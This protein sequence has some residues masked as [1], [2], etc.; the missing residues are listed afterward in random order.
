MN[1]IPAIL[2]AGLALPLAGCG[3][4]PD[5]AANLPA[6]GR[7]PAVATVLRIPREGGAARLYRVPSLE[8]SAWKL[9]DK[10]PPLQRTLG[11]DAEQGFVF[12]L[13]KKRNVVAL[14]LETRR[15]R[16]SLEQVRHATVGPDGALY[17]VDTGSAVTQMMRRTPVRFRSKFQGS[18][19]ELHGTMGGMLVARLAGDQPRVEVLGS[20][21]PP[22]TFAVPTGPQSLTFWGD[23]VAVAAD[24]AVVIYETE[25]DSEGERDRVSIPVSGGAKAVMFSPS[26]HRIYVARASE[27]L[28]ILDRVSGAELQEI[29]LPGP[30][31][32]LVGDL[33]GQW[34]LVRPAT[35]DSAWVVDVGRGGF[36]GTVDVEWDDDLPAVV[37]PNT[38]LTRRGKDL[39]AVDLAAKGF[40]VRGSIEGGA[41]DSW[42]P[43]SWHP[44]Q[45]ENVPV[46]ADSAALAAA[47]DSA[48][49]ASV[50]LQVSSS[51]NPAWAEELSQ[52]LRAA[53]LPA[54]V[55]KPARS[56]EAY[57]VVL[58][59]YAT[60]EQAEETGRGIGMPSFVVTTQDPPSQ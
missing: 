55:L 46:N 23:L 18:P 3:G 6:V 28:L 49:A 25:G 1:L 51:Q 26:G 5:L 21:R 29:D 10:L 27:G 7:G 45:E 19:R 37:W 35:G 40:P 43:L 48:K 32:G 33:F 50:Y 14:D 22:A 47:A 2:A 24:S 17:A 4:E 12:L 39:A 30:A 56:D 9:E 59:P 20:D 11:A 44:P 42:L 57:R 58:G 15:L 38:L 34:V 13:D 31:V 53:G 60:R 54:T 41:G 8:P 52:R 16:Q 36:T